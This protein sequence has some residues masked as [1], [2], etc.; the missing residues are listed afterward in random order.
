MLLLKLRVAYFTGPPIV[1]LGSDILELVHGV[2]LPVTI[3][4]L[5]SGRM[6]SSFA[7]RNFFID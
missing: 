7:K 1:I 4:P 6:F 3:K 2:P 5:L